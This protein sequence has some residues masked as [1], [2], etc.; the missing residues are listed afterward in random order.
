M[1]PQKKLEYNI[2]E[3]K[4]RNKEDSEEQANRILFFVI[5]KQLKEGVD[6][7]D[8]LFLITGFLM[9]ITN[10]NILLKTKS[11][12]K[13]I[14][15]SE[16]SEKI[17]SKINIEKHFYSENQ[18]TRIYAIIIGNF[19]IYERMKPKDSEEFSFKIKGNKIK[20][21]NVDYG[22]NFKREIT[23]LIPD[24]LKNDI[25]AY[26]Q[27]IGAMAKSDWERGTEYTKKERE[28][29]KV[30][31]DSVIASEK[32]V[33]ENKY[34]DIFKRGAFIKFE[35]WVEKSYDDPYKK[36]SFIFKKLKKD[37]E[38]RRTNFNENIKWLLEEDYISIET[39]EV[40]DRKNNWLTNIL[41]TKRNDLYNL[42]INK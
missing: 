20:V 5:Q 3:F 18:I 22:D 40:F 32:E 1:A 6:P 29:L 38:L 34:D 10:P 39:W 17:S 21:L 26:D 42:M 28:Y 16:L 30:I 19:I 36:F 7:F 11:L 37:N 8:S 24:I 27:L 35:I 9:E 31:R 13:D 23:S 15:F 2:D 12:F 25:K 41:G 33:E 14:D 4:F